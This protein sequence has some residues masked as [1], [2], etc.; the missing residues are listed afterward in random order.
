MPTGIQAFQNR[1]SRGVSRA[2][3]SGRW[4]HST[5]LRKA[6]MLPAE[7]PVTVVSETLG[8]F[9]RTRNSAQLIPPS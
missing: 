6:L 1:L 2:E 9:C 5:A 8:S 3:M 4:H 7:A